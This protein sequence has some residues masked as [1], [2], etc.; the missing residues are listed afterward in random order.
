VEEHQRDP[1]RVSGLR[2]GFAALA[3]QDLAYPL[4]GPAAVVGEAVLGAEP[5][6]ELVE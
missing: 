5:L 3:E 4:V 2:F 6:R 1:H